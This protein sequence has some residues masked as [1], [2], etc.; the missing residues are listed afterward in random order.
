MSYSIIK[1]GANEELLVNIDS[2][3]NH[4]LHHIYSSLTKLGISLDQD[5]MNLCDNDANLA[6]LKN[7]ENTYNCLEMIENPISQPNKKWILVEADEVEIKPLLGESFWP[8]RLGDKIQNF[9]IQ[10]IKKNDK[11][12]RQKQ[13]STVSQRRTSVNRSASRDSTRNNLK[14][15]ASDTHSISSRQGEREKSSRRSNRSKK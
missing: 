15:G 8:S 14:A 13:K 7:L 3:P 9:K 5:S 1:Y 4:L 12:L 11:E 6:D 10:A 2:R